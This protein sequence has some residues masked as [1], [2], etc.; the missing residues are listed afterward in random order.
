MTII[1]LTRGI[2]SNDYFAMDSLEFVI[3]LENNEK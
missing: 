2:R 1:A 3:T